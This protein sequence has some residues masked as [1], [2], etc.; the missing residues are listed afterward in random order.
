MS[1][2]T[3][4]DGA[5]N[6]LCVTTDV[7]QTLSASISILEPQGSSNDS[8]AGKPYP[9]GLRIWVSMMGIFSFEYFFFFLECAIKGFEL[10]AVCKCT[11]SLE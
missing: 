5:V 10:M 3:G 11:S 7:K 4:S 2:L 6:R 9:H 8:I 1:H